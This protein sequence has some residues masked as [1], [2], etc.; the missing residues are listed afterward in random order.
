MGKYG[1]FFNAFAT[2][3]SAKTAVGLH[4]NGVGEWFELVEVLMTGSGSA[5]AA[6][7][8]HRAQLAKCTFATAGTGTTITAEPFDDFSNAGRILAVGEFSAEPTVVGSVFPILYGF[9]QRGGMRWAVPRG[10]GIQ[11]Y[12][13]NTNKGI[14]F[15]VLSDAAGEVDGHVHWHES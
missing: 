4:A 11:V 13:A 2:T 6:D 1:C 10:E 5:A 3:T 9:N 14:V 7:R 12:N 15:Q 8:Q